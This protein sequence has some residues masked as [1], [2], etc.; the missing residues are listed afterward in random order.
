MFNRAII[1]ELKKWLGNPG[2]KPLVIR[3]A[4]QVGKT[5]V[6]H[7]FAQQFEQYIYLNLEIKE[8]RK[9][10]VNYTNL[11]Q[12][13]Q[14]L[15][16]LKNKL[17]S[18]KE[19]TLIFIDE[20]QEVPEALNILRYFYEQEPTIKV[21][22]AGS[23]L[24]SIF[25]KHIHFPVGRIEYKV[26]RPVSFPEFLEASGE[27]ATLEQLQHI[28]FND[29]AHDKLLKL[30]H[31]YAIIGGMPE[32]VNHYVQHKDLTALQSIFD[33]LIASYLD[34]VEKYARNDTQVL[35]LRH[36]I[37]SSFAE[38]GKRI[39]FAGFGNSSYRSRE[40]G[41]CFRTLEK[42]L[43]IHLLYPNT[44]AML[45]FQPDLKKSPRLQIL[46]TGMLN[47][48][49][50]I[51][52]EILGTQ[53]LSKIYQ[54]TMVEHLTGQELLANQYHALSELYFWVKEKKESTAE[55]D[56]LMPYEGKIIPIETKSGKTG[57]LRSLH[58]FMDEAPHNM[59]VRFYSRG[60]NIS[61]AKTSQNK[62]Y[63]LLNLPY[64]LVSQING[65]L[66]WFEKQISGNS[67]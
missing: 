14:T 45:P 30:Y 50:G 16:F 25:D 10:F 35:H 65:Y 18:K 32:V 19:N 8:D 20:I 23:M 6:I 3:G 5:T 4:R 40:M 55:L 9:P 13:L 1:Q 64:Y 39:K 15:F 34:D 37:R 54:G 66:K 26:L 42:V 67:L 33:S 47:H 22:A 12:L 59:A 56:F 53:D 17:L 2:R 52:K 44:S 11:E 48:F 60:V 36:V 31:Q 61:Q 43:L 29:F 51:Q 62:T 46:D 38:A 63:F 28:P 21:V 41:E 27:T 7:Q 58:Q 49:V 24:E 57:T